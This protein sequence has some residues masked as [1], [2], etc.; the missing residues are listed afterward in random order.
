MSVRVN[1]DFKANLRDFSRD[2]SRIDKSL[3]NLVSDARNV[4]RAFSR[5]D[6]ET[7][8]TTRAMRDL[9]NALE[10]TDGGL[11]EIARTARRANR[12]LDDLGDEARRAERDVERLDRAL[13][14][15]GPIKM[16]DLGDF[17]GALSG[18]GK[19]I[20]SGD[21]G[22]LLTGGLGPAALAAMAAWAA[23]L[24]KSGEEADKADG[25]FKRLAKSVLRFVTGITAL[26]LAKSG[27]LGIFDAFKKLKS[28]KVKIDIEIPKPRVSLDNLFKDWAKKVKVEFD[29]DVDEPELAA[30][31]R[32]LASMGQQLIRVGD[33]SKNTKRY[34]RDLIDTIFKVKIAPDLFGDMS[35][36]IDDIG[37][38]AR[39]SA[40]ELAKVGRA[41]DDVGDEARQAARRVDAF[42]DELNDAGSISANLALFGIPSLI[43]GIGRLRDK[44]RDNNDE[45]DRST[46]KLGALKGAL[47]GIGTALG[48][49]AIAAGSVAA[50]VAVVAAAA[51]VAVE[52]AAVVG[53]VVA[54]KQWYS[55]TEQVNS[56]AMAW[57]D[58]VDEQG[59]LLQGDEY[60]AAWA[61]AVDTAGRLSR[62]FQRV[63]LDMND[64]TEI[65]AEFS[66][67]LDTIK[68]EL[69]NVKWDP[70]D[71]LG[72][73]EQV[74]TELSKI[75]DAAKRNQLAFEIFGEEGAKQLSPLIN[76]AQVLN[77][78]LGQTSWVDPE[79]IE[80]VNQMKDAWQGIKDQIMGFAI[81]VGSF[82]A[83]DV[84]K[85]LEYI[86]IAIG[87]V[88]D[89]FVNGANETNGAWGVVGETF[90]AFWDGLKKFWDWAKPFLEKLWEWI[91]K[92]IEPF[93]DP[94]VRKGL[95]YIMTGLAYLT[96]A[97]VLTGLAVLAGAFRVMAGV[98][99]GVA[100]AVGKVVDAVKWLV[101]HTPS[102]LRGPLGVV[103]GGRSVPAASSYAYAVPTIPAPRAAPKAEDKPAPT[104]NVTI[105]GALDPVRTARQIEDILRAN[106]GRVRGQPRWAGGV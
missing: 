64:V 35:R 33:E 27:L 2:I 78:T 59:N 36:D 104:Y 101:N 22:G 18:I 79:D 89:G 81:S 57:G 54:V 102:W 96:S 74:L 49:A 84:V 47:S 8:Q 60:T 39:E 88:K 106:Q 86:Q 23:A 41:M 72:N 43:G 69:P 21:L 85:A 19:S 100:Y 29:L 50:A 61:E 103:I 98:V 28:R 20:V 7:E 48:G 83:P 40:G 87:K 12:E 77:D 30:V 4:S 75:P 38:E 68:R 76:N 97:G 15:L 11:S 91:K 82:L 93:K 31:N 44:L 56:L 66:G 10:R 32:L 63:G 17:K 42:N 53:G 65:L 3:G 24:K 46:G 62:V 105:N 51:V 55:F 80:R 37:D 99:A 9:D 94:E 26:K 95:G 92:A 73:L 14:N 25:K 70:Y 13:G 90:R 67:H 16:P 52:A 58:V 6:G 5:L 34:M 1:I 45:T 71:M